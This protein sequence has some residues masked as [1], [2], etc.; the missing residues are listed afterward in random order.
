MALSIG[1]RREST[2]EGDVPQSSVGTDF[3]F[4][5]R[6]LMANENTVTNIAD[7]WVAAAINADN[8]DPFESE[9]ELGLDEGEQDAHELSGFPSSGDFQEEDVLGLGNSS[10]GMSDPQQSTAAWST[11][12]DTPVQHTNR[13]LRTDSITSVRTASKRPSLGFGSPRTSSSFFHPHRI[14]FNRH[15]SFGSLEEGNPLGSPRL[16]RRPSSVI[17]PIFAHTGVRTPPAVLEAQMQQFDDVPAQEDGETLAPIIEGQQ[18][19]H[20]QPP[21]SPRLEQ[22]DEKEPSLMSLLPVLVIMQY[23]LLAL[24]ATTHDQVFYLYLVS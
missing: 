24:H 21:P 11:P 14:S 12:M 13:F 17:P 19:N 20:T 22:P 23:G 2:R 15:T 16:Q 5:Q 18:S 7:L 9:D 8:E 4:A 3:N 1:R 10:A 6:L